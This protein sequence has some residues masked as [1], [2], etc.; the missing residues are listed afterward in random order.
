MSSH[1]FSSNGRRLLISGLTPPLLFSVLM[2]ACCA[3]GMTFSTRVFSALP[4]FSPTASADTSKPSKVS[5]A[6]FTLTTSPSSNFSTAGKSR[7]YT[8]PMPVSLS[9]SPLPAA[10]PRM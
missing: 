6:P 2:L 10:L 4:L 8:P 9:P 1:N 3:K 7:I 5:P